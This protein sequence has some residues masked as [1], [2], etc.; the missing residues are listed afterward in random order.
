MTPYPDSDRIG[1]VARVPKPEIY[2]ERSR[3][4]CGRN[5]KLFVLLAVCCAAWIGIHMYHR[6][7]RIVAEAG[8]VE[9]VKIMAEAEHAIRTHGVFAGHQ[10]VWHKAV[11]K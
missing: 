5:A 3:R 11:G 10:I 2:V 9:R 6:E 7:D 1:D 4:D 8:R